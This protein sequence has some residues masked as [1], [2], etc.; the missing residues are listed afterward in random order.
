MTGRTIVRDGQ[1][2]EVR[3]PRGVRLARFEGRGA[4]VRA[5][6]MKNGK[7]PTRRGGLA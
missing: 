1:A 3:C 6:T 2:V 4:R 5:L 7:P